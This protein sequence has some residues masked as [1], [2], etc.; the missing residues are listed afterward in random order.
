MYFSP[1][2]YSRRR[3]AV[4]TMITQVAT[5]I[6]S[7]PDLVERSRDSTSFARPPGAPVKKSTQPTV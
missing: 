6:Q 3:Q 4:R 7:S 5:A 1:T 2:A